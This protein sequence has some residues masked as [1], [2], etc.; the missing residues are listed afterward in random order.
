MTYVQHWLSIRLD[1]NKGSLR[2]LSTVWHNGTYINFY[3]MMTCVHFAKSGSQINKFFM[4][5]K[6]SC[7]FLLSECAHVSC[8]TTISAS[9]WSL[10]A[11][12]WRGTIKHEPF[13]S[14]AIVWVSFLVHTGHTGKHQFR[15]D[16]PDTISRGW[17]VCLW[18]FTCQEG[19]SGRNIKWKLTG[20]VSA[21]HTLA[22]FIHTPNP[23]IHM[24]VHLA[25]R[26]PGALWDLWMRGAVQTSSVDTCSSCVSSRFL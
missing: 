3:L 9:S 16:C 24:W 26:L 8:V 15:V 17:Q 12:E 23:G 14:A 25:W 19:G 22:A 6:N 10:E 2:H 1:L 18:I 7:L 4:S 5:K 20:Q 13:R 21:T 11:W